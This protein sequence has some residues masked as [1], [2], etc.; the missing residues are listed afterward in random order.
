MGIVI[1]GDPNGMLLAALEKVL[2]RKAANG[3]RFVDLK[4]VTS[5]LTTLVDP[6]TEHVHH[7]FGGKRLDQ[8]SFDDDKNRQSLS[9]IVRRGVGPTDDE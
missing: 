3:G 6:S 5:P 4:N 2:A 7:V 9:T 8:A 1:I